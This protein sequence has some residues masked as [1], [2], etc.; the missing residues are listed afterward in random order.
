[1]EI[2]E[3]LRELAVDINALV[4]DPQNARDHDERNIDAI[5]TSLEKFGQQKPIVV[6]SENVIIAGN[7]TWAAAK[8]LGWKFIAAVEY[9]GDGEEDGFA[10]ADNRT[11][12]LAR[13]NHEVLASKL[14]SLSEE[15]FDIER[16]G[17]Q[18]YEIAPLLEA[19]WKPPE[20]TEESF[21]SHSDQST[22]PV[23]FTA[24]Q[25]E[26]VDRAIERIRVKLEDP[27]AKEGRCLELICADWLAGN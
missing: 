13:W 24:E 9:D 12:E 10:L 5:K 22:P 4:P 8:E 6:N 17:W 15:G 3:Q 19:D 16:L 20:I 7:G 11:G 21:E 23:R 27:D 26:V 14:K 18:D 25:R 2:N 1:M